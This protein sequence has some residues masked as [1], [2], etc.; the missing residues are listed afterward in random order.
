LKNIVYQPGNREIAC[1]KA[2]EPLPK[3]FVTIAGRYFP[4][5]ARELTALEAYL[6]LIK[7]LL[8]SDSLITTSYLW[9]TDLHTEN[10]FVNPDDPTQ[11]IGIIDWQAASLVPLY[12]NASLPAL[13]DYEGPPLNGIERPEYPT[14]LDLLETGER[15]RSVDNWMDMTLAAYCRTLLYHKSEH[16]YR[17]V[18]FRETISYD[19]LIYTRNIL[20]DGEAV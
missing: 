10:I 16:L 19:L 13:L 20:I 9:H 3:P 15:A 4:T 7:F 2:I 6:K 8:P 5:R 12:E 1:V 11:I 14:D 18:E 17:A